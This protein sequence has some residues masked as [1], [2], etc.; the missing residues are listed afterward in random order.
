M[1]LPVLSVVSELLSP[2]Y[3]LLQDMSS[4]FFFAS[5]LPTT[6]GVEEGL[7]SLTASAIV[8]LDDEA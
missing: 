2:V 6:N 8:M 1:L 7:R 5:F 4:H 3:L